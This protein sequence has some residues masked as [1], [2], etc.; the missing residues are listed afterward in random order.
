[1]ALRGATT[2]QERLLS[3]LPFLV[4]LLNTYPFGSFIFSQ[5]PPLR[6]LFFP[7]ELLLPIYLIGGG[8]LSIV[9]L[10]VF[11]GLYAGVVRNNRI[12]H[13]IRYNAMQAIMLGISLTIILMVLQVVGILGSSVGSTTSGG[14]LFVMVL[15][16]VLFLGT[17]GIVVFSVV[18]SLR[19]HHAEVPLISDAAYAQTRD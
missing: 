10:M 12:R 3:C 13:L 2:T 17:L 14:G 19:G 8:G 15:S 16:N 18:Q 1:M 4:P 5:F 7:I 9:R 6:L 11:I